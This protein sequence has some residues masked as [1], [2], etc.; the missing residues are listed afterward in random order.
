MSHLTAT[1]PL[2]S[3]LVTVPS[4]PPSDSP[5]FQWTP[6][7]TLSLC[8]HFSSIHIFV[9]IDWFSPCNPSPQ[10]RPDPNPQ[11]LQPPH[12]CLS[13]LRCP[14]KLS[15]LYQFYTQKTAVYKFS[16]QTSSV[17]PPV[18]VISSVAESRS[19]FTWD[20]ARCEYVARDV[21]FFGLLTICRVTQHAGVSR[22]HYPAVTHWL[23]TTME[24]AK[25]DYMMYICMTSLLVN[26]DNGNVVYN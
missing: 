6:L 22:D 12:N 9:T 2:V 3:A 18:E 26:G 25:A 10:A 11:L 19:I 5:P 15:S 23:T 21:I 24:E 17:K 8:I 20:T 16:T 13:H 7:H 1:R 14:R 4:P